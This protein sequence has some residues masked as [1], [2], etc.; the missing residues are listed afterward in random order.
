MKFATITTDQM[1]KLQ[2]V[3]IN[4]FVISKESMDKVAEILELN[5]K[6]PKELTAVRNTIVKFYSDKADEAREAFDWDEFDAN[7]I[8]MSGITAVIDNILFNM[9]AL[10]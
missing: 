7:H 10:Y 2:E 9:G 5:G 3:E 6:D 8:R 4:R 1:V